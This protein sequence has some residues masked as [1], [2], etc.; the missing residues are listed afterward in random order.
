MSII[1]S[2]SRT[3][4]APATPP[5]LSVVFIVMTPLPPRLCTRYSSKLVRFPRPF[6]PATSSCA[7]LLT[8][9]CADH[10]IAFLGA[11]PP[12]ANG[13]ATLVA[14]FLLIEANAHPVMGYE[15][16]FILAG[17]QSAIDQA[18]A[19]LDLDGDDATLADVLEIAEIRLLHDAA[20]CREDDV[21]VVAPSFLIGLLPLDAD[22]GGDFLL[23]AQLEQVC[24]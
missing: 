1:S 14:H 9:G 6:S 2:A 23:V 4:S 12:D 22:R 11:N 13:V 5:V 24:D 7:S 10:I 3:V 17:R 21:Q 18:V 20:A 16:D 8:N 15:H 19:V